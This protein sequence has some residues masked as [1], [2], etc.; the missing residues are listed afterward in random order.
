MA[1]INSRHRWG[2]GIRLVYSHDNFGEYRAVMQKG[3][4]IGHIYLADKYHTKDGKS[5]VSSPFH[6]I[7]FNID[8]LQGG[9]DTLVDLAL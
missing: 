8:D 1:K 5:F 3:K 2:E 9:I 6:Y 4:F 7:L